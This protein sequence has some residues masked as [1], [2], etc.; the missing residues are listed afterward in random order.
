MLSAVE[1]ITQRK[2]TTEMTVRMSIN[3]VDAV[4]FAACAYSTEVMARNVRG[5]DIFI[6]KNTPVDANF[7]SALFYSSKFNELTNDV[8]R[9]RDR[10]KSILHGVSKLPDI[11]LQAKLAILGAATN[12]KYTGRSLAGR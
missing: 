4:L 1:S 5:K 2:M 12:K 9:N 6:F 3:P 8:K 11:E 7:Y 10:K